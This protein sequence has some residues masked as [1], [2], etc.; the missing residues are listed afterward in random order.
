MFDLSDIMKNDTVKGLLAKVGVDEK[1]ASTMLES[2]V[3]TIKNKFSGNKDQMSSLLAPTENTADDNKMAEDVEG[4]FLAKLSSD[5]N[6]IDDGIISKLKGAAMPAI[7][8]AVTGQMKDK[9]ADS[10]EGISG[11]LGGFFTDKDG[12]GSVMDDAM[13]SVKSKLGGFFK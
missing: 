11:M 8:N 6:G 3:G 4:E 9:G 10:K 1:Q 5:D 7:L 13:D 2:A 12:D